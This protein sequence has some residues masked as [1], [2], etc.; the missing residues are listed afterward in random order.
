MHCLES[1]G[2]IPGIFTFTDILIR[3]ETKHNPQGTD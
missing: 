2:E 1:A 3:P